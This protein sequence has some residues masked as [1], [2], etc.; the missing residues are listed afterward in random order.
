MLGNP[1]WTGTL[2]GRLSSLTLEY[3]SHFLS[4]FQ[5]HILNAGT[6]SFPHYIRCPERGNSFSPFLRSRADREGGR[7]E[8]CFCPSTILSRLGFLQERTAAAFRLSETAVTGLHFYIQL[9]LSVGYSSYNTHPMEDRPRPPPLFA[10][11]C[12]PL[13]SIGY[14]LCTLHPSHEVH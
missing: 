5:R 11:V 13:T 8:P 9:C 4:D 10:L 14:R 2:E 1:T 7:G 12:S 3:L 6:L